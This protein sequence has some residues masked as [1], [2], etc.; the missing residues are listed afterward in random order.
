M[1]VKRW[2]QILTTVIDELAR[3]N[4]ELATS[5]KEDDKAKVSEGKGLIHDIGALIY[6]M[7]HD[8]ELPPLERAFCPLLL[9]AGVA[10]GGTD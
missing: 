6:E 2:P 7:R 8:R 1:T 10:T 4:G 9:L 3:I 5:D